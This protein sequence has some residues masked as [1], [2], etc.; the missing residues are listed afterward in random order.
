MSVSEHRRLKQSS[1]GYSADSATPQSSKMTHSLSAHPGHSVRPDPSQRIIASDNMQERR[2]VTVTVE[3]EVH[4][5]FV[6]PATET[7][8][9]AEQTDSDTQALDVGND[10]D[11][12][13]EDGKSGE[14]S[15][16]NKGSQDWVELKD[17]NV[18][19]L[20]LAPEHRRRLEEAFITNHL[21]GIHPKSIAD[22]ARTITLQA[23]VTN[24]AIK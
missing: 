8:A 17:S 16:M 22:A 24:E 14:N 23:Q 18:C 2:P 10:A 4:E 1:V 7:S 19:G 3:A 6:P 21:H 13:V 15:D 9:A 11:V 20:L 5:D 12:S